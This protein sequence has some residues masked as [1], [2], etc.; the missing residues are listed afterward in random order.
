MREFNV[1]D[2]HVMLVINSIQFVYPNPNFD[3]DGASNE[4]S[5]VLLLIQTVFDNNCGS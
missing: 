3:I 5:L 4:G 2:I 1:S